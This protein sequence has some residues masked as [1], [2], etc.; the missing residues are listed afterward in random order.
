MTDAKMQTNNVAESFSIYA[1]DYDRWF[2]DPRGRM[3]FELEVKAIRTLMKGLSPPFLEVGVGSGRFAAALGIR[4]GVDPAEA[5]LEMAIKR[6]VKAERAFGEKLPFPNGI[7]GGVF[8]LFTLC[9]VDEPRKV[10]AEAKRV[11]KKGG[12][13]ILGIINRESSWGKL[14][15]TKAAEGHPLYKHARFYS[16]KEVLTLLQ[17]AELKVEAFSSILCLPPSGSIHEEP[18]HDRLIEDAGL[19]CIGARKT[20]NRM[21]NGH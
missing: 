10:I 18:A 15:Q 20:D 13:L 2:D 6:G 1:V 21:G 9:F 5:L 19:V 7:F 3:L 16:P 8:I 12:G 14:Y 11:L 17:A 4:Y